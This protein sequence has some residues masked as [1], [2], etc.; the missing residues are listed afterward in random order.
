MAIKFQFNKTSLN[1]L[2]KQKE[3][4]KDVSDAVILSVINALRAIG[5]KST[6]P[7]DHFAT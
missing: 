7:S 5:D 4:G 2:N 1:D 6:F 3:D